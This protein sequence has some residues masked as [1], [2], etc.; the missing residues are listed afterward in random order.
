MKAE[1]KKNSSSNRANLR[2]KKKKKMKIWI[3]SFLMK[4]LELL[5][6]VLRIV[7]LVS[8]FLFP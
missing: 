3:F 6:L 1:N 2:K 5:L 4:G 8:K 7:E